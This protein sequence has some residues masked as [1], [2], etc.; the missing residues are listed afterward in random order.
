MAKT[1]EFTVKSSKQFTSYLK[2]FASIDS[3]VLFEVDLLKSRFVA[4]SPNE[5]RS[6]VK[7]GSISFAE[8]E[9]ETKSKEL[10]RIKT[11]VYKIDHLIKIIDQFGDEFKLIFKYDE[12]IE[13]NNTKDYAALAILVKNDDL[14]FNTECTSLNIFK[15]ISDELYDGTIRQIQEVISFDFSKDNIEKV[16]ALSELDK[17]YKLIEFKNKD[18]NLYAKGELF[19]YL[20]AP[21]T[22]VDATIT[23]YKSQFNKVD[24]E[25]CKVVMG[26][27]RMSFTSTDTDTEIIVSRVEGNDKYDEKA[28]D[29]F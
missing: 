11:G 22:N 16:R 24:V 27:D 17:E 21:T 10:I 4:K 7:F 9:F 13:N 14:K 20:I 18:G 3:T 5:E 1:V 8:A 28:D 25:N 2:K 26:P 6:I 29:P 15:Y 19:E 23:F 12:V